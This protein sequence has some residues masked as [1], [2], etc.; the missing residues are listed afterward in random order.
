MVTADNELDPEEAG[1]DLALLA[2][3][4]VLAVGVGVAGFA[5]DDEEAGGLGQRDR[6]GAQGRA[7]EQ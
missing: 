4:P 3:A 1:G 2:A 6:H 7:V 5:V